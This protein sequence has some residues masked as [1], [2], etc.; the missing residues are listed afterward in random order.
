M[1]NLASLPAGNPSSTYTTSPELSIE[2]IDLVVGERR[3]Q[4]A[5]DLVLPEPTN[6]Q[7]DGFPHRCPQTGGESLQLAVGRFYATR[8]NTSQAVEVWRSGYIAG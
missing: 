5:S 1:T 4:L 6:R 3:G 7:G 8:L 2:P